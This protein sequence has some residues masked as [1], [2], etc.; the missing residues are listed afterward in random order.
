[1]N[2]SKR[3]QVSGG[4]SHTPVQTVLRRAMRCGLGNPAKQLTC[5][6]RLPGLQFGGKWLVGGADA[7]AMVEDDDG[8]MG[9]DAD[10]GDHPI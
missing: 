9:D 2:E 8:S 5:F 10:E 3:I 6:H 1:M 7:S 4:V